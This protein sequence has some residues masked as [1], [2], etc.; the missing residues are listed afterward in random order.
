MIRVNDIGSVTLD[1]G[2]RCTHC[3]RETGFGTGLFVDRI[4]S[5]TDSDN[6]SEW[7]EDWERIDYLDGYL[8]RE[9]LEDW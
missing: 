5:C 2:D 3:G 7:L 8:C 1:I 4:P 6:A 9:C